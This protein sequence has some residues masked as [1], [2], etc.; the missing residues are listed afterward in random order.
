MLKKLGFTILC[1]TVL[2]WSPPAF[3]DFCKDLNELIERIAESE[4]D[5]SSWTKYFQEVSDVL[6]RGVTSTAAI[7]VSDT[8][9]YGVTAATGYARIP[10]CK[11]N[12]TQSSIRY[13]LGVRLKIIGTIKDLPVD[14]ELKEHF[15]VISDYGLQYF[16]PVDKVKVIEK[17][18]AYYFHDAPGPHPLC[19][20][21]DCSPGEWKKEPAIHPNTGFASRIL[22]R[23]HIKRINNYRRFVELSKINEAD[24]TYQEREF[25]GAQKEKLCERFRVSFFASNRRTGYKIGYDSAYMSMCRDEKIEEESQLVVNPALKVVTL[26]ETKVHFSTQIHGTYYRLSGGFSNLLTAIKDKIVPTL[27]VRKGCLDVVQTTQDLS[28]EA[29]LK[30]GVDVIKAAASAGGTGKWSTRIK[31]E[32]PTGTA[33]RLSTYSVSP[34]PQLSGPS[35][36]QSEVFDFR[37]TTKCG[38]EDDKDKSVA[39]SSIDIFN[40]H[41]QDER[42]RLSVKDDMWRQYNKKFEQVGFFPLKEHD[43]LDHGLFFKVNGADQFYLWRETIK[44]RLSEHTTWRQMLNTVPKSRHSQVLNFFTHLIMVAT[45]KFEG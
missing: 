28:L 4:A 21:S 44:A 25:L 32:T 37:S 6:R 41:L 42:S 18:V 43:E 27:R 15:Y 9:K 7:T 35:S 3:A 26:S 45:L 39:P 24:L 19:V 16:V 20:R 11:A 23:A 8:Q 2:S 36:S 38:K 1:V 33:F 30:A 22:T 10:T 40:S 12:N 34:L 5:E 31:S 29:G 13:N 17:G 14:G